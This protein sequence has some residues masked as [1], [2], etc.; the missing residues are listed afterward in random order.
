M[1]TCGFGTRCAAGRVK[2]QHGR[3]VRYIPHR[4]IEYS[5]L[6]FHISHHLDTALEQYS[7]YIFQGSLVFVRGHQR[8]AGVK[9][10]VDIGPSTGTCAPASV[11]ATPHAKYVAC[12]RNDARQ[13]IVVPEGAVSLVPVP[14]AWADPVWPDQTG[15]HDV[16]NRLDAGLLA[17][18]GWGRM[19]G[20]Y[21]A[22]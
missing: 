13:R 12:R 9:R 22:E 16:S 3:V 15:C 8:P 5:S 1:S 2:G 17:G 7:H 11:W 18:T 20:R 19:R 6:S 21:G 4:K 10:Q 14:R